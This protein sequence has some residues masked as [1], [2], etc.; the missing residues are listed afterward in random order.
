MFGASGSVCL[1]VCV[2]SWQHYTHSDITAYHICPLVELPS[3]PPHKQGGV[4]F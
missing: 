4:I 2:C 1:H 3:M